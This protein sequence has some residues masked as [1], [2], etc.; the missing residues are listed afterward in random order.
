MGLLRAIG[1]YLITSLV[2]VN[3][4]ISF[5][6]ES[7]SKE[8]SLTEALND[9]FRRQGDLRDKNGDLI[10]VKWNGSKK[11]TLPADPTALSQENW[12]IAK[13]SCALY[14]ENDIQSFDDFLQK[15]GMPK[16]ERDQSY[17]ALGEKIYLPDLRSGNKWSVSGVIPVGM[18]RQQVIAARQEMRAFITRW[19]TRVSSEG[20]STEP[21]EDLQKKIKELEDAIHRSFN[22]TVV[23][24][25]PQPSAPPAVREEETYAAEEESASNNDEAPEEKKRMKASSK[26]PS[27]VEEK[28]KGRVGKMKRFVKSLARQ[29]SSSSIASNSTPVN[30]ASLRPR[31]VRSS[32]PLDRATVANAAAQHAEENSDEVEDDENM[33][34]VS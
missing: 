21:L 29:S 16:E 33:G 17:E 22:P 26:E 6:E 15:H 19:I 27:V 31:N 32:K 8:K 30:E 2:W 10:F 7:P 3:I 9:L 34:N 18:C 5:P 24:T 14:I 28:E 11:S 1:C 4:A 20:L 25:P 23:P 12:N 13:S